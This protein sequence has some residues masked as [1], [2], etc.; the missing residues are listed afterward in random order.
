MVANGIKERIH[1]INNFPSAIKVHVMRPIIL[2]AMYNDLLRIRRSLLDVNGNRS[3]YIEEK[4]HSP[5]L[6]LMEKEII[7]G[8]ATRQQIEFEWSDS[9]FS[10]PL[11]RHKAL[12][13]V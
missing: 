10:E 3:I 2:D 12:M 11:L 1:K 13:H 9:Q 4:N 8:V 5:F 7:E 6:Y